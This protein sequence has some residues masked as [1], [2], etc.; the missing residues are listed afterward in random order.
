MFKVNNKNTRATSITSFWCFL[1]NFKGVS[2]LLLVYCIVR[3]FFQFG[4][5]LAQLLNLNK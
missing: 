2:D 4:E 5:N 3:I 1:V